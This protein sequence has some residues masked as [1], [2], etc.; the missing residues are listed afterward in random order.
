VD[1]FGP[2]PGR[3][4]D[5][6]AVARQCVFCREEIRPGASVCP[7]CGSNL[8]PLQMLADQCAALGERLTAVEQALALPREAPTASPE[9]EVVAQRVQDTGLVSTVIK[10]PHMVDNILL[11][12]S[13]LVAAHWIA[14]TVPMGNRAIFRIVALAVALPFGYRFETNARS[15]LAGQVLAALAFASSGTLLI[16]MLDLLLRAKAISPVLPQDIVATFATIA[17][18]HFAGGTLA[19]FWRGRKERRAASDAAAQ[20]AA[21]SAAVGG[22]SHVH[23]AP[24]QIKT[25]AETVKAIYD[26]AMPLAA[27]GAALW[28]AIGHMFF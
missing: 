11:G 6:T 20:R 8:E 5:M 16:G 23:L 27:S 24:A 9:P 12:L 15:D 10:W 3:P 7:H 21:T 14:S 17:L 22:T 19:E 28:A 25:T 2:S 1:S 13:V 4:V 26:A 18:S